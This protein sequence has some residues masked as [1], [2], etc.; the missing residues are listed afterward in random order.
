MVVFMYNP[1]EFSH[2]TFWIV[3][4]PLFPV[5]VILDS[6]VRGENGSTKLTIVVGKV[7]LANRNSQKGFCHK[8]VS[9]RT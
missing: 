6:E 2:D 3:D 5:D 9:R 1:F 7:G 8:N 4:L